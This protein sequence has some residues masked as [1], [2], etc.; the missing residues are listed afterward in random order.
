[1]RLGEEG[2]IEEQKRRRG[3]EFQAATRGVTWGDTV[4][5]QNTRTRVKFSRMFA[6]TIG[7]A[8]KNVK[9]DWTVQ[10]RGMLII[11]ILGTARS[12]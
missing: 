2:R 7:N 4:I 11:R 10:N 3:V 12:F 5:R 8:P 9:M 1:M 6:G